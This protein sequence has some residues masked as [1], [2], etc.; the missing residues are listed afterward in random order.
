MQDLK[1]A[2]ASANS[3]LALNSGQQ[4]TI[5]AL[6]TELQATRVQVVQAQKVHL[7]PFS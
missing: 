2:Q 1:K 3:A 6:Q 7:Q 5:A 4:A